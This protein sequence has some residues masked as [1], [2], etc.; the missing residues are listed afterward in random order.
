[1]PPTYEVQILGIGK[2]PIRDVFVC[3][4]PRFAKI[5]AQDKYGGWIC[6][7][8]VKE[9]MSK[10][11]KKAKADE[12]TQLSRVE[13]RRVRSKRWQPPVLPEGPPTYIWG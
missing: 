9:L 7:G 5:L 10:A 11:Q 2:K 6:F 1:M 4:S 12:D 13:A 3:N 8:E